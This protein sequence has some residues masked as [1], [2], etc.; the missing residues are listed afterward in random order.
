[1]TINNPKI[2][3]HDIVIVA[4]IQRYPLVRECLKSLFKSDFSKRKVQIHLGIVL[5]KKSSI[6][7]QDIN[8]LVKHSERFRFYQFGENHYPKNLNTIFRQCTGD[9]IIKV[10][11]DVIFIDPEWLKKYE[12]ILESLNLGFVT[13]S[14][15]QRVLE[16]FENTDLCDVF[17]GSVMMISR[18]VIDRIGYWC[19]DYGP[20]LWEDLDYLARTEAAGFKVKYICRNTSKGV[21]MHHSEMF[22]NCPADYKKALRNK[23][24]YSDI[25]RI[26]AETL[27]IYL[28]NLEKY[29]KGKDLYI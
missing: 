1:M 6:G 14:N 2:K 25:N 12:R 9:Y 22:P 3:K 18:K 5:D 16:N 26:K 23:H 11:D 20:F 28:K 24:S 19:E 27:P 15:R 13:M 8:F 17:T 29:K 10:D 21:K 7:L 4:P